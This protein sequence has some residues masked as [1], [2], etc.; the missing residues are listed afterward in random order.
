MPPLTVETLV[1]G[2][3][4]LARFNGC[5][6][7]VPHTSA[8]DLVRAKVVR[9][10]KNYLE[11]ELL[12]VLEPGPDRHTPVCPVAGECGGCQWQ[13]LPYDRQLHWKHQL[14]VETL[15]H[16]CQ[17]DVSIIK[18]IIPS[19][20]QWHYRSRVQVKCFNR[21]GHFI[22]GFY[23]PRSR[24]V[25]A[26]D[27][28][29]IMDQRLNRLLTD[30]RSQING[31]AFADK[32]PQIDL[33]VDDSGKCVAVVHY[34][35][36]QDSGL[37][38]CLRHSGLKA[39]VLVQ[40]G[41]RKNNQ[42]ICGDGMLEIQVDSPPIYL[43]YR[44]G[45]FAQIN[46][47]QNRVLVDSLIATLPWSKNQRVLELFCGMGNLS[48]PLAR[49]V[50]HLTGIEESV[51]SIRM[52]QHNS[53]KN[54]ITNLTFA[55]ASAEDVLATA[56]AQEHFDIVV[57]DPPRSG[58]YAVIKGLVT[59]GIPS[60]VYVSCDPQTLARDLKPLVH[61]GYQVVVTQPLDMFPQTHHCESIT[62]LQK[63]N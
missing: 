55:A 20:D 49:R 6:V 7:F 51:T 52:A 19:A 40:F 31:S 16:Q 42:T 63:I 58:A 46:L 47:Q 29:P 13:H 14:F 61:G 41:S 5:V 22:T 37:I 28:C 39:D 9:S 17:I 33:A 24:Y 48:F 8:G 1:N 34:L 23:R 35:G 59:A 25:V 62:L 53:H 26:V 44:A 32:I 54:A 43:N 11:T 50:K 30:L 12:E 57:L 36:G 10:K 18:P 15:S 56:I 2:G 21:D 45:S 38:D 3:S 4:G 60:L 27:Q